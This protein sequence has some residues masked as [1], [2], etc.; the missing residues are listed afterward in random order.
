MQDLTEE[1][2]N[3]RRICRQSS[4]HVDELKAKIDALKAQVKN[5]EFQLEKASHGT[6]CNL[7][8]QPA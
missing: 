5:L 2:S 4:A 7:N 1:N 6:K 3:L 8:Y